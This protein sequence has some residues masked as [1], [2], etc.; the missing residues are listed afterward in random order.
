MEKVG[1]NFHFSSVKLFSGKFVCILLTLESKQVQTNF[2]NI[3]LE[4]CRELKALNNFS[5]SKLEMF[6]IFINF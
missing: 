1:E 2:S 5:L 6:S 4:S 3:Q